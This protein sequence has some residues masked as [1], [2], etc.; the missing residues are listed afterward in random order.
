MNLDRYAGTASAAGLVLL[1]I[2]WLGLWGPLHSTWTDIGEFIK[3]LVS[4]ATGGAAVTGA[5]VAWRGL[6]KWRAETACINKNHTP[7][8]RET[9]VL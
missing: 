6:E 2:T 9:G 4:I 8:L 1:I 7:F 3:V 5:V